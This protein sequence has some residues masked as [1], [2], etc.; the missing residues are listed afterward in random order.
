M[1]K[2][3]DD[4]LAKALASIY[5][6]KVWE[7][8]P[9]FGRS[10]P[11]KKVTQRHLKSVLHDL[12]FT[13]LIVEYKDKTLL[14]FTTKRPIT[15]DLYSPINKL[16]FEYVGDDSGD[17]DDG[18]GDAGDGD[19]GDGGGGEKTTVMCYCWSEHHDIILLM[20]MMVIVM[21]P[22]WW[23]WWLQVPRAAPFLA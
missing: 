6:E 18:D 10:A 21:V 20:V 9:K 14:R 2:Y 4:S 13:D 22:G 1:K 17:G 8:W 11:A 16:A 3:Y 23:W 5:P 7:F 19:D 15:L 12:G